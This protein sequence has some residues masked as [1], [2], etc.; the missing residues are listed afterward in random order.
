[1]I[2]G[3]TAQPGSSALDALLDAAARILAADSLRETLG[4]IVEHLRGLLPYDDLTVY[5]M[6]PG[7]QFLRPVFAVGNWVEEIMAD[8]HEVSSGITGWV[9]R[10]RRTRNVP[11][12]LLDPICTTVPGT[13]EEAE[14]FVCVPLLVHDRV[15]GTLNVY[16]AGA[17]VAFTDGEVAL[18]ERFATMA[19]LAYD[20]ARQRDSLREQV[21]T[22]GL[23][24]L[25][26][27]RG[28]QERLRREVEQA[29]MA[30]RGVSLV[31]LDLDHFK[32]INDSHGHAEGDKALAAA[33]ERLR[34]AVRDGDAVGRLGGEEFLLV[35]P[36]VD[37]AT[38]VETAERARMALGVVRVHGR[39]LEASAG[40]ATCP[41]DADD[42]AELLERAD[43]ALY[44]AKHGGRRQTRRY[45]AGLALRPSASDERREIEALLRRPG[46]IQPV[47]QPL[48]ELATGRIG[49][50]EA[51]A[52]IAGDR[53]PD[54]WFG[55]AHRA[56]LGAELEAAALYAA[57]AVPRRPPGTFL[58]VNVSPVALLT[59]VVQAA[60]PDD[61]SELVIELTEHELFAAEHLL[62]EVLDE[63]R[64]RGAR[65]ALDD[66]GAG[67]AGLQQLIRVAPDILKLDR[68]LVHGAHADPSRLALI[69][70]L[71]SF[72]ADTGAAVC[73][74]GIEDLAD[75]RALARVDA[76]Y[77]QGYALARPAVAW[78]ELLPG[79]AAATSSPV[80]HGVRIA[81]D[82]ASGPGT[83]ARGLAELAG[84][85]A[86][87]G[88]SRGLKEAGRRAARLLEA[89]DASLMRRVGDDL[90]LLSQH[91]AETPGSR[92]RLA[93]FP[94]TKQLL[95][96]GRPGQI[97][98][99]DPE[100]D[101]AEVAELE[102]L[103]H[104]AML[105]IPVGLG[106]DEPGL[107]EVY[108]TQAQA[109]TSGEIDRARVVALQFAAVLRRL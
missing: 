3:P 48:L 11:N 39:P 103:G 35:L 58:S 40:V 7:G 28:S 13:D 41:D 81:G 23:T 97:V 12:T 54:Q 30:G 76:T 19:A 108:R 104:G 38:A 67:Y 1:V 107:L 102:R 73:G 45:A 57:L 8:H 96:E 74:E 87:L 55:Q 100:S 68:S 22:D 89:E 36:G 99:G 91:L 93:D 51:L 60:L 43:A 72:A 53:R 34:G 4:R 75:L 83:W 25:L 69:E 29:R 77:A 50:Y 21:A 79:A 88:D 16:R 94:A 84:F 47:F 95:D 82:A 86:K 65:V 52:R 85:L 59:P 20:S 26:N 66:A 98:V 33:A 46:S 49:G 2:S 18:V 71:A 61:L 14:A 6:Q 31:V 5:E 92:W 10:N 78:P 24:G 37:G 42:A 17:D 109:F 56:G 44:A 9:V 101:P 62:D 63:L 64:L 106:D 105:M 90:E 70:A 80:R 32:L 27:H 15:V